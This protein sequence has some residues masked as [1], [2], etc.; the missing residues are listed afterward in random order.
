MPRSKATAKLEPQTHASDER[1]GLY[2][3]QDSYREKRV[4]FLWIFEK[5]NKQFIVT[6][7]SFF[8]HPVCYYKHLRASFFLILWGH[9]PEIWGHGEIEFLS[10]HI[11][12][13][14]IT[15]VIFM[16]PKKRKNS[17]QSF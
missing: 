2:R 10:L 1:G 6:T 5:E 12:T 4:R 14:E 15:P 16:R 17:L 8:S 7:F 11:L 13:Y 3:D 9:S